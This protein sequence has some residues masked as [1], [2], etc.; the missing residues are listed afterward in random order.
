MTNQYFKDLLIS[1]IESLALL[2]RD[3]T[4]PDWMLTHDWMVDQMKK[5]LENEEW[6]AMSDKAVDHEV[7][8]IERNLKRQ[9]RTTALY[10]QQSKRQRRVSGDRGH[11]DDDGD[12]EVEVDEDEDY[13][14]E[15]DDDEEAQ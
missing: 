6:K 11:K 4:V 2:Y 10:M 9:R 12:D 14:Y 5:A 1:I 3:E 13:D 15:A 7:K 8:Q